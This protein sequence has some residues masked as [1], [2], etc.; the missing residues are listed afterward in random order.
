MKRFRDQGQHRSDFADHI[1]VVCPSCTKPVDLLPQKLACVHCGFNELT[2]S[3]SRYDLFLRIECCGET[4]YVSNLKHLDF[5]EGYV[6]ADL[7]ERIPNVNKS[8]VSRL[9][10]WV[11]SAKNR[12]E[13]LKCLRRA[14]K[15]LA[16][17]N[18]RSVFQP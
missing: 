15:Q 13:V 6:A 12:D 7:R 5:L 17:N 16:E 9:P 4:L 2:P 11:K 18:Y 10:Q 1:I 14:R 3:W 8:Q